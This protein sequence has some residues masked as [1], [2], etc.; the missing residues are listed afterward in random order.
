MFY[1]FSFVYLRAVGGQNGPSE[2]E[3]TA[4]KTLLSTASA[5]SIGEHPSLALFF[6]VEPPASSTCPCTAQIILLI[7][8]RRLKEI[9]AYR[10]A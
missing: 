9:H 10:T 6:L 1:L 7:M 5:F 3:S 4:D 2:P 8:N